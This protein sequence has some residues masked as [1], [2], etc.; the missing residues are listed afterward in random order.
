M[1]RRGEKIEGGEGRGGKGKGMREKRK[2]GAE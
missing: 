2:Y 1:Q